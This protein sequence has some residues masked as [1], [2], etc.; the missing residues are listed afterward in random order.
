MMFSAGAVPLFENGR[1]EWTAVVAADAPPCVRY[2]AREFT[3]AVFRVSG[4]SIPVV[5][6]DKGVRHAV[7]FVAEGDEWGKERVRY[8]LKDGDLVFAG[9]QPRAVLLAPYAFLQRE[10]GC[11][12]LWPGEDG[13]FYPSAKAWSAS[14]FRNAGSTDQCWCMCVNASTEA[15]G[16]S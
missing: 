1:T 15:M 11:R 6:S 7:R 3:N 12:W 8:A 13:A 10:L 2:A 16:R 9:N 14:G 5:A 4:A